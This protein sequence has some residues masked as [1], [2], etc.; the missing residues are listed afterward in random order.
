MANSE[1]E[2]FPVTAN[3]NACSTIN[4]AVCAI[5]FSN[6][7]G[8]DRCTRRVRYFKNLQEVKHLHCHLGDVLLK[9]KKK[10][11]FLSQD[12]SASKM[13]LTASKKEVRP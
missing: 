10:A 5:P 4:G 7:C 13:S 8:R 11:I 1:N 9:V 2:V 6:Q 3:V 12:F